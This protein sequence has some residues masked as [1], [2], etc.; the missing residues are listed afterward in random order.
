MKIGILT[1]FDAVNYGSFLQAFCLQEY[2]KNLGHDVV[3]VKK[4]SLIYEKWRFTSLFT[5]HPKKIAF[6]RKLSKGYFASWKAFNV[7]RNP[8]DLD[9]LIVGSDEMWELNNVTFNTIPEY[10]GNKISAKK[11]ITYAVSSNSTKKEDILKY[12]FIQEGLKSFSSVSVRDKSTYEAYSPYLHVIPKYTVDPTLIIDIREYIV[13]SNI[14]NYILCY[15]YTFKDYMIAAVKKLAKDTGKKI[16]VVGQKFDW[17]DLC[18]PATP[19]EF[20]GLLNGADFIVTDTFHGTT[21]S[22]ALK[23]QFVAFAYK[24]KVYRALEL[25]HMLDRDVNNNMELME[26]YNKKIDYK[27]IYDNYISPLQTQSKDYLKC[28]IGE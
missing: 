10:F 8:K 2:L 18:I 6:K 25:F 5:Y 24:T 26:F 12:P 16:I 7:E 19:F 3:M 1:V 11:K 17:A 4:N 23:K 13:K 14:E 21:L 27:T 22:I 28:A 20:L 9:V 15:T